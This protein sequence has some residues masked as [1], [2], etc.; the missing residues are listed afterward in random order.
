MRRHGIKSIF[1]VASL[2]FVD[3]EIVKSSEFRLPSGFRA[4]APVQWFR[5]EQPGQIFVDALN[6]LRIKIDQ[7]DKL[8]VA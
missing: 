4:N 6:L 1:N 3:G 7:E 8:I 5:Q 2:P